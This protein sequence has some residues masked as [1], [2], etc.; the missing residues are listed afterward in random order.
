MNYDEMPA[1]REMDALVAEKVMGYR[2]LKVNGIKAL[3]PP[4]LKPSDVDWFP[5]DDPL[6]LVRWPYSTDIAAAWEVVEHNHDVSVEHRAMS[7]TPWAVTFQR[8]MD[9][10]EFT[11]FADTAPLAICR[12]ALKAVGA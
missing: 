3:F 2:W 6:D 8:H 7:S 1:G 4:D 5:E 10:T 12:A 9:G 11:G